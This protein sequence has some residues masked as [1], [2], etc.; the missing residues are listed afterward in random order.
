MDTNGTT[1]TNGKTKTP[2][3]LDALHAEFEKTHKGKTPAKRVAELVKAYTAAQAA[4]QTA[5]EKAAAAA[6]VESR[7]AEAIIR[8]CSGKGR[9]TIGGVNLMPMSRGD[10]V[11]FRR[12]GGNPID[13]GG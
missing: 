2:S 9:V 7:A 4:R 5:D 13:L 10:R 11:F 3:K 1:E 8:E 12:E 6:D